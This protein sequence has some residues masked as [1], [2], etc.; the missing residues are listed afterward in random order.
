MPERFGDITGGWYEVWESD[1]EIT[2]C[3]KPVRVM[4]GF[5]EV[6]ADIHGRVHHP[7]QSH[8]STQL[9]PNWGYHDG[10]HWK[11]LLLPRAH[12]SPGNVTNSEHSARNGDA[13]RFARLE[14]RFGFLF[15]ERSCRNNRVANWVASTRKGLSTLQH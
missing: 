9:M 12:P 14:H 15:V 1:V 4:G 5:G 11:F 7:D 6:R 3:K 13:M 2:H 10:L 8:V